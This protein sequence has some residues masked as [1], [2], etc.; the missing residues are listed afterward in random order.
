MVDRIEWFE[1][2]IPANGVQS[3][4]VSFPMVFAF[5]EV[6]EIDVKIPPGPAGNLGFFITAGGSQYIP[7]TRGSFIFPD[8]DYLTWPIHNAI[9][10]GSFGLT[11]FNTDAWPHVIQVAFQVNEIAGSP[12]LQFGVPI[13]L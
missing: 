13:G 8:N 10:S 5:G 4:P 3:A 1:F 9:T 12:V 2:T 6:V 11:A 7:R